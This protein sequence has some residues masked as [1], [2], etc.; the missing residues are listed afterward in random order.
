MSQP[1][2]IPRKPLSMSNDNEPGRKRNFLGAF[3]FKAKPK[4]G[5]SRLSFDHSEQEEVSPTSDDNITSHSKPETL[6]SRDEKKEDVATD[7]ATTSESLDLGEKGEVDNIAAGEGGERRG[8]YIKG[9][10]RVMMY[11]S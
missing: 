10:R 7:G 5:T 1:P 8:E 9:V 3:S 6:S 2:T 4:A 11:I